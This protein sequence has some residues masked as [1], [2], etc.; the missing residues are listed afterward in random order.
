[1]IG[2]EKRRRMRQRLLD[3]LLA[4][5]RQGQLFAPTIDT[6]I[7]RAATSRGTFYNHFSSVDDALDTLCGELAA[8]IVAD[9]RSMTA[10]AM[11]PCERIALILNTCLMRA[12]VQPALAECSEIVRHRVLS[13][14]LN[15][16]LPPC[17]NAGIKAGT[18][19]IPDSGIAFD[20]ILGAMLRSMRS[21]GCEGG[22]RTNVRQ[23]TAMILQA[24]GLNAEA[25]RTC[26]SESF[27]RLDHEAPARLQWWL[28]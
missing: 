23:I 11:D 24:L 25:A 22:S 2:V 6:V 10:R 12:L 26:A 1:M 21:I 14:A 18:L 20:L 5:C 3:G 15:E 27:E 7:R 28:P 4:L 9:C 16:V 17:L 19:G 13:F 8:T